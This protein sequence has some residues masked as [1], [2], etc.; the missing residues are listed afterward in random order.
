MSETNKAALQEYI[1]RLDNWLHASKVDKPS[2]G[3]LNALHAAI[4]ALQEEQRRSGL[5]Y[6]RPCAVLQY[7]INQPLAILFRDPV[8]I[9]TIRTALRVMEKQHDQQP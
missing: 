5:S 6:E 1:R 3:V 8:T 2:V 9:K 7:H 4:C